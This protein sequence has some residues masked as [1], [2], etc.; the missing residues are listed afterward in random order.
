MSLCENERNQNGGQTKEKNILF[1]YE[2]ENLKRGDGKKQTQKN[3]SLSKNEKNQKGGRTK[4][5][6]LSLY[7]NEN[8]KRGDRKKHTKKHHVPMQK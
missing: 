5:T 1:L 3:M 2:N 6:I 4:K 8:L 7:E